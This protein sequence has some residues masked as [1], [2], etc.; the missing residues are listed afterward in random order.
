MASALIKFVDSILYPS[1]RL[2]AIGGCADFIILVLGPRPAGRLCRKMKPITKSARGRV[3]AK[4][5]DVTNATRIDDDPMY[6]VYREQMLELLNELAAE[7]GPQPVILETRA[8][9]IDDLL[10]R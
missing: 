3:I 5:C 4:A 8:D 7:F 9:Y 6:D 10:E 2:V 1:Y